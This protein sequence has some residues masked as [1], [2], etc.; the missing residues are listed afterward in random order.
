M[1]GV[2][3]ARQADP[4]RHRAEL[5]TECRELVGRDHAGVGGFEG[6]VVRNGGLGIGQRRLRAFRVD[7]DG[8]VLGR[9]EPTARRLAGVCGL[10]RRLDPRRCDGV[11]ELRRPS[12]LAGPAIEDDYAARTRTRTR[13]ETR[14]PLAEI[15]ARREQDPHAAAA[16]EG[17]VEAFGRGLANVIAVLDPSAIVLGGGVSNLELLY[18]EGVQRVARHVFND[19]LT[20]PILAPTLGDSAGVLGA[21]LIASA[22]QVDAPKPMLPA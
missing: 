16:I 10:A 6:R 1:I 7:P 18:T 8:I 19:E 12:Y 2:A 14:L 9:P 11:L 13:T 15:A 4:C 5:G 20:T 17:L 22:R 21:A 3:A